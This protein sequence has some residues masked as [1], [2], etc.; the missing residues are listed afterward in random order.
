LQQG[1]ENNYWRLN[2]EET[3]CPCTELKP[4]RGAVGFAKGKSKLQVDCVEK[5]HTTIGNRLKKLASVTDLKWKR[6]WFWRVEMFNCVKD[7]TN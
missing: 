7:K 3:C 4:P 2:F 6:H 1:S 5:Q